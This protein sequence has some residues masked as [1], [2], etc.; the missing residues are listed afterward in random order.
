MDVRDIIAL[1]AL[2]VGAGLVVT[3]VAL[4]A[5]AGWPVLVAGVLLAALGALMGQRDTSPP[6][7]VRQPRG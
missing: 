6:Q 4:V 2:I 1:L 5:P 3:G 7:N